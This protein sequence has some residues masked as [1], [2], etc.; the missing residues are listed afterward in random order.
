MLGTQCH[1][2]TFIFIILELMMLSYQLAYYLSRPQDRTRLWYLILLVLMILY[3]VAGGLFPD[4]R[5]PVRLPVQMM[6]AYGTGFLMASYF[7]FYFYKAFELH[8]LRWHALYGVPL[9]LMLPYLI[10]FVIMY[11]INGDMEKTLVYGMIVPFVYAF[12]LLFV[13]FRAIR[14]KHQQQRDRGQYAKETA[15][16]FAISPWA[17]LTVFGIVEES[18]VLEVICTNTGIIFISFIFISKAIKRSRKEY[19]QLMAYS[20]VGINPGII[21][22]NSKRYQLTKRQIEIVLLI[23]KGLTYREIAETLFISEKTVSNHLQNVYEKTGAGNKI[24]LIQ[25]L[26]QHR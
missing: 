5:I 18:Q 17:S 6:I 23:Q 22:H 9:F 15:M 4:P 3:N 16:Y 24:Q 26:T 12:I 1:L 21:N 20:M 8:A 2:I 25:K 19:E 14:R 11:A 7:P 13:M 10:F